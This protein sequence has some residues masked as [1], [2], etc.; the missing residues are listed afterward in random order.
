MYRMSFHLCIFQKEL[1]RTEALKEDGLDGI[2]GAS[3]ATLDYI[4]R[5]EYIAE[6]EPLLLLSHAYTRYLGDLSGGKVLARVVKRALHPQG[7]V[8]M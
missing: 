4:R 6:V 5:I 7:H 1:S 8:K 3:P 2:K